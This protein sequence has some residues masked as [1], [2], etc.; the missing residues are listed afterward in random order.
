MLFFVGVCLRLISLTLTLIDFPDLHMIV[1]YTI[2][3]F[4]MWISPY[5]FMCVSSHTDGN[6][7]P[8][9]AE[10]VLYILSYIIQYSVCPVINRY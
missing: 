1:P 8:L 5:C 10:G 4:S 2:S 3:V 9:K 6:I 7:S